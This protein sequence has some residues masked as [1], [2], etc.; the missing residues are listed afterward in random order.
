MVLSTNQ[1]TGS[2]RPEFCIFP[3]YTERIQNSAFSHS[4]KVLERTY[5]FS[6]LTQIFTT[7]TE[8]I[9]TYLL[10]LFEGCQKSALC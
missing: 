4:R 7:R 2:L 1:P 8:I 6:I 10:P 9:Y 5:V 3:T